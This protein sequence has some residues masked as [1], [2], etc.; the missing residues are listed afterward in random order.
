V[1]VGYVSTPIILSAKMI[2]RARTVPVLYF[3]C[4]ENVEGVTYLMTTD[5]GEK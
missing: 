1:Y 3:K 4:N 5:N 2:M